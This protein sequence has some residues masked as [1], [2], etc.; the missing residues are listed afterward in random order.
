LFCCFVLFC[1]VLFSGARETDYPAGEELSES[2]QVDKASLCGSMT[3][4]SSAEMDSLLGGITVVGC[5]TEGLT[6]AAT[7]PSTNGASP[8]IEKPPG[9]PLENLR[10]F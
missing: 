3:S 4:N 7:S 9:T 8:V 10:L 5:S 1:F 2:G 6:G